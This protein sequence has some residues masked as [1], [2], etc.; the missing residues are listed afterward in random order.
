MDASK[1]RSA[2]MPTRRKSL[3]LAVTGIVLCGL[4]CAAPLLVGIGV[5][6][7]AAG[8]I[9]RSLEIAGIVLLVAAIVVVAVRYVRVRRRR[10]TAQACETRRAA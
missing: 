10:L 9:G 5:S 2:E 1:E 6:A 4:C 7:V 8:I 3:W